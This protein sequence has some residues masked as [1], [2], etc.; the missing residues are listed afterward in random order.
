LA[1]ILQVDGHGEL[2]VLGE[3]LLVDLLFELLEHH[4]RNHL[5]SKKIGYRY[6]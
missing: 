3:E 1:L 2:G 6:F 5:L 4:I